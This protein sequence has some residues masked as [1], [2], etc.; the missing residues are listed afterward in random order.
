[1]QV[2]ACAKF[3]L[4]PTLINPALQLPVLLDVQILVPRKHSSALELIG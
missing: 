4:F 1:M 2:L 3:G